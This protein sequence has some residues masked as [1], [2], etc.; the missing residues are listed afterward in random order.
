MKI[1]ALAAVLR[2]PSIPKYTEKE[3]R[4]LQKRA[5]MR[6]ARGSIR[7]QKGYYRTDSEKAELKK[8]ALSVEL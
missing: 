1:R 6:V 7:L 3:K 2:P 5:S 8:R 4:Q